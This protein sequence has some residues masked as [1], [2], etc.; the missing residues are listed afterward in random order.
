MNRKINLSQIGTKSASLIRIASGAKTYNQLI[1]FAEESGAELGVRPA[2]RLSRALRYFG[3]IYNE[4]VDNDR[5]DREAKVVAKKIVKRKANDKVHKS[6][7]LAIYLNNS[8]RI[9]SGKKKMTMSAVKKQYGFRKELNWVPMVVDTSETSIKAN[10][11]TFY[12]GKTVIIKNEY[13]IDTRVNIPFFPNWRF[14]PYKPYFPPE[15]ESIIWQLRGAREK[16]QLVFKNFPLEKKI[17][18][19]KKLEKMGFSKEVEDLWNS[20]KALAESG[21]GGG[22]SASSID[23]DSFIFIFPEEVTPEIKPQSFLAALDK[24]A[25]CVFD[26]ISEKVQK[27]IEEMPNDLNYAALPKKIVK[28][29]EHYING[30]PDS[31]LQRVSDELS[32][33]ITVMDVFGKI[34]HETKPK[35]TRFTVS[36]YNTRRDHLEAL[37][38]QTR[39]IVTEEELLNIQLALEEQQKLCVFQQCQTGT[40]SL[41]TAGGI[42]SL[43]STY[44][45]AFNEFEKQLAGCSLDASLPVSK[46]IE[47]GVRSTASICFSQNYD[48]YI[49]QT[50]SYTQFKASAFYEGFMGKCS[51]FRA[52]SKI[53]G[54]G[55]Y[56]TAAIDWTNADKKL[57]D[58]QRKFNWWVGGGVMFSPIIRM[59]EHYGAVVGIRAGCWGSRVDFEF[60]PNML[61]KDDGVARYSRWVGCASR[62]TE[63]TEL[64]MK[65]SKEF[66]AMVM[67]EYKC[68]YTGGCAIFQTPIKRFH[69]AHISGGVYGYQQLNLLEQLIKMDISK[70]IEVRVDGIKYKEHE[71]E[72]NPTFTKKP[73]RNPI[74]KPSS[75]FITGN[76][77][78]DLQMEFAPEREHCMKELWTGAGGCGKTHIQLIDNGLVNVLYVAPSHKLERVK[79]NEYN[80][81]GDVLANV[82]GQTFGK[83]DDRKISIIRK[84]FNVFIVD[85]ASMISDENRAQI[86]ELY[87]DV[88]L[89]FCGDVG[90]QLPSINGSPIDVTKFSKVTHLTENRRCKDPK[91]AEVLSQLRRK[92]DGER[93]WVEFPTP[94]P[95]ESQP[96]DSAKDM[97]LVHTH[98]TK[99][100]IH[101]AGEKYR[102]IRNSKTFSNGDIVYEN[103]GPANCIAQ[104][105]FT[106]HSVQ[107]ETVHGKLFIHEECFR[108]TKLLYTAVSRAQYLD[109]IVIVSSAAATEKDMRTANQLEKEHAI[110]AKKEAR[111]ERAEYLK[112]VKLD[113]EELKKR[114]A[115]IREENILEDD[116][117]DADR[118]YDA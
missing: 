26:V 51:D 93:L 37:T 55:Y 2:T 108:D 71:F 53:N 38:G 113:I 85:E 115:A 106:T 22:A 12:Q 23:G 73:E 64:L 111:R 50:K 49:D 109:Q 94:V 75:A 102:V 41:R 5:A 81:C 9:L 76:P 100:G 83:R 61:I 80:V 97:I 47:Y 99:N 31:E 67:G 114:G 19:R 101:V 56:L 7:Q 32:C 69:M 62:M 68:K 30:V 54:V 8:F 89:I 107:G 104:H 74:A 20:L 57:K 95:I 43:E 17:Q 63:E 87:P 105:A 78:F 16:G 90:Y 33:T 52:T 60:G 58:I 103:I 14:N 116:G 84:N 92:I 79:M 96:Y 42:F 40:Y 44:Q 77:K 112:T 3:E 11:G 45:D 28:L 18:I 34:L 86:F 24:K 27:C 91:L 4:T 13:D 10:L 25:H 70:I 88:K 82:I 110:L 117:I 39:T 66:A 1:Q 36:Y 29:R 21:N 65:C 35:R 72:I 6:D 98:E 48:G 59:L 118:E 46:F 15:L